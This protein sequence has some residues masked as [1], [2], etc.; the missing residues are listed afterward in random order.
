MCDNFANSL[1][2]IVYTTS[3]IFVLPID[4]HYES[5][6]SNLLFL[7]IKCYWHLFM[8]SILDGNRK[9][10]LVCANVMTYHEDWLNFWLRFY[11][12]PFALMDGK[13]VETSHFLK[14]FLIVTFI[15]ANVS[16]TW[17]DSSCNGMYLCH[18]NNA[19]LM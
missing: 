2:S 13:V 18:V 4:W 15:P 19:C 11:N 5:I 12:W 16:M 7:K 9:T 6:W 10:S 17:H 8:K 3:L 14:E 1:D